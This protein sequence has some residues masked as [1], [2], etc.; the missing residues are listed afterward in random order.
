MI[1]TA[2]SLLDDPERHELRPADAARELGRV[3]LLAPHPDDESL[4]CGGLLALL[5]DA[6]A[7][8]HIIVV[9]DGSKSHPNSREYPEPRLCALREME[10]REAAGHL[11]HGSCVEFLRFPDCGLPNDGDP[12]FEAAADRLAAIVDDLRPHTLIVPWR[13]DPHCDHVATWAL[14]RARRRPWVRWL[15]YP[16]WSWTA[17]DTAPGDDEAAAWRI[18]VTPALERKARAI[19][20][21]R[22]QTT[23]LI[24]DDPEGFQLRPDV[25]AHFQ[26]PWE[27]YLVP[28][29]A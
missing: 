9:T 16:V 29:D 11:G 14:A 6:G 24:A 1:D 17:P 25:L 4:G 15:E 19:A 18:D 8:A 20:A 7:P 27:L 28:H 13:R 12:E 21:H 3:V 10:A 26:R 5:A 23:D 22:S 2:L